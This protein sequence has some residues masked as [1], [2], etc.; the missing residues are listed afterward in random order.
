MDS[1]NGEPAKKRGRGRPQTYVFS[2]DEKLS[3]SMERLKLTIEKRRKSQK[4][5]YHRKKMEKKNNQASGS[6]SN[7]GRSSHR[8]HSVRDGGLIL[9]MAIASASSASEIPNSRAMHRRKWWIDA[10]L[11]FIMTTHLSLPGNIVIRFQLCA[12]FTFAR[13]GTNIT[14]NVVCNELLI[15]SLPFWF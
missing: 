12:P 7:T 2:N 5:K 11:P 9:D 6:S 15:K 3:E 14:V 13:R 4:D 1:R 8:E 10:S